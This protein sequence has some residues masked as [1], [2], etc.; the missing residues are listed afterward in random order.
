MAL[1]LLAGT[2]T[3]T[4][5]LE[6][7]STAGT[8]TFE[9][10]TVRTG[11]GS[12]KVVGSSSEAIYD[13]GALSPLWVRIYFYKTDNP[14][15]L[16]LEGRNSGGSPGFSI[17]TDSSGKLRG[18][19]SGGTIQDSIAVV[20]SDAWHLLEC[21]YTKGTGSDAVLDWK[22]DGVSQTSSTDG[23]QTT[24]L[25]EMRLRGI[26]TGNIFF[27][28]LAVSNSAFLGA[29]KIEALRP[30]ADDS[31][32]DEWVDDAASSTTFGAVDD[33]PIDDATFATSTGGGTPSRQMW[34]LANSSTLEETPSSVNG[35]RVDIRAAR[36][37]GGGRTHH[38]LS[39]KSGGSED[40]SSDLVLGVTQVYYQFTPTTQPATAGELDSWLCGGEVSD[41][42]GRQIEMAEL[43]FMVDYAVATS[44]PLTVAV[45]DSNTAN[46][47]DAL[48]PEGPLGTAD[49]RGFFPDTLSMG[50]AIAQLYAYFLSQS[51]TLTITDSQSVLLDYLLKVGSSGSANW[52]D[53]STQA[54]VGLLTAVEADTLNS[55]GDNVVKELGLRIAK[56]DTL[57]M[58]DSQSLMRSYL[59]SLADS[60][61]LSDA[62][63]LRFA[64]LVKI[65][66][67]LDAW[68]DA[69]SK[70]IGGDDPNKT[71]TIADAITFSD[72]ERVRFSYLIALTEDLDNWADV[73]VRVLGFPKS[74]TDDLDAWADA[75]ARRLGF[76]VVPTD[77]LTLTDAQDL[78]YAYLLARGDTLTLTDSE[79]VQFNYLISTSDSLDSWADVVQAGL[80]STDP[81]VSDNL[82]NWGD[83]AALLYSYLLSQND[84]LTL[85]DSIGALYTFSVAPGDS[86]TWSDAQGKVWT[87]L[88]SVGDTLN[89]WLD[90]VVTVLIAPANQTRAVG[91]TLNSWLDKIRLTTI[92]D[93]QFVT[94]I[95]RYL[96]DLSGADVSTHSVSFST[97]VRDAGLL[98]YVR[99]YLNDAT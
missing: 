90:A 21:K 58:A 70:T 3:P 81:Q 8:V 1:I 17:R 10:T 15:S 50:D 23:T 71:V 91:D 72:S 5:L 43:W 77:T 7:D 6:P 82:N 96:N 88:K 65:N 53:A 66:D 32:D 13:F 80:A 93:V 28:D 18:Q 47:G 44:T 68:A 49:V 99:R 27:D 67:N 12:L 14:N 62:T 37:N 45:S 60:F 46:W 94:Y 74:V 95:R 25:V 83:G 76:H 56:D 41:D 4:T 48:V 97:S 69:V 2:E 87:F 19:A 54:L 40:K 89:N 16:F 63:L 29:G 59:L 34:D 35:A 30:T 64:Y 55:W 22:I 78:L 51:D 31:T 86:I 36:T 57:S 85:T 61:T 39:L 26:F 52:S 38:I 33:N 24:D 98:T 79:L 20:S 11:E 75:T 9:T 42:A 92:K 84:S 73:V